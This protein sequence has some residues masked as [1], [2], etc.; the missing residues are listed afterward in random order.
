[1]KTML[2]NLAAIAQNTQSDNIRMID[3]DELHESTANFFEIERIEEFAYTILGQ[4]GVKDNLIVRPLE[5]GGYEIISGH[6]RRAAVQYLLDHGESISRLLPCLIQSYEDEDSMML[7]LILMNVSARQLSDQ[8]LWQCYEK[9]NSILQSKKEAG[10]RFGRVRETIAQILGISPSQVG[11]LQNVDRNAI[12]PVKEAV[13]NGDISISTANVIAQLDEEQQEELSAGD[14]SEIKPKEIKKAVAKKVDTS[15]NFSDAEDV[16][17]PEPVTVK[18][19]GEMQL[20]AVRKQLMHL[21]NNKLRDDALTMN[22]MDFTNEFRAVNR[23]TGFGF[24]SGVFTN[25]S[26]DRITISFSAPEKHDN[27][28]KIEI[29]WRM[30]AKFVQ[31]WIQEEAEKVDTS[32]NSTEDEVNADK[33]ETDTADDSEL[34]GQFTFEDDAEEEIEVEDDLT[35]HY[36]EDAEKVVSVL[37][38]QHRR[39]M[40][41]YLTLTLQAMG[42]NP[43][44]ISDAQLMMYQILNTKS[45]EEAREAYK[46][47]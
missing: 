14:L 36:H 1:M 24:E 32:S 4:G 8:E 13:A 29:T 27:I 37:K 6:R 10:E 31:Q 47:E 9:L 7:D 3:I 17:L 20:K 21:V 11:K 35:D 28:R 44:T 22:G 19:D 39:T 30:A 40:I 18:W 46:G 38:R 43:E 16:P 12:E 34:D 25:C 2:S 42:M 45:D 41:G 5:S 15:S 33:P 23:T 26:Y